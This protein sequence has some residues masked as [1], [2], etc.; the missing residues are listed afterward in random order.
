MVSLSRIHPYH[1]YCPLLSVKAGVV[2]SFLGTLI[3]CVVLMRKE[4]ELLTLFA[5]K[6]K[7]NKKT[8]QNKTNKKKNDVKPSLQD[9]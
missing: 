9:F 4:K 2:S 1:L 5:I 8:K 7:K 3:R 6:K